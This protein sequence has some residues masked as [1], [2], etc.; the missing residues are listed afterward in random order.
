MSLGHS[1]KLLIRFPSVSHR[2]FPDSVRARHQARIPVQPPHGC[3]GRST[4]H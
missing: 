2:A 1:L 4:F 3:D